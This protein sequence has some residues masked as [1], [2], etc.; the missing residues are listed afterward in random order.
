V[1]CLCASEVALCKRR[2]HAE[3]F[4]LAHKSRCETD[5]LVDSSE[6]NSDSGAKCRIG[7]SNGQ[8]VDGRSG[9]VMVVSGR[10]KGLNNGVRRVCRGEERA[11]D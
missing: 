4:V 1:V 10:E 6:S 3:L 9:E 2:E 8:L 5:G 11:P 7:V